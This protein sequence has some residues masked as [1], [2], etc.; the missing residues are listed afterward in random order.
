MW[1]DRQIFDSM[2][3]REIKRKRVARQAKKD[4]EPKKEEEEPKK[5]EEILK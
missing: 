4:E 5:D 3:F 1:Y 2:I